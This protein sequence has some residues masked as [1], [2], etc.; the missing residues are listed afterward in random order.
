MPLRELRE[1]EAMV[2]DFVGSSYNGYLGPVGVDMFV[3]HDAEGYHLN[4]CVEINL[5]HTM[6][7]VAHA[8]AQRHTERH[9][10]LWSP[11]R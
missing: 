1:A 7:M 6:G 10:E 3:Y 4:P 8:I 2:A 11:M 5:R 9:G